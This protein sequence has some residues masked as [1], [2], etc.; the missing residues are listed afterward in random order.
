MAFAPAIICTFIDDFL[1]FARILSAVSDII[2]DEIRFINCLSFLPWNFDGW[3]GQWG[4]NLLVDPPHD[5]VP[6]S[7]AAIVVDM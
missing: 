5:S 7:L 4:C 2:C 3:Q 6:S 1:I